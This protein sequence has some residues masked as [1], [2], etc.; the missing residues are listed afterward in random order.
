VFSVYAVR[1]CQNTF[2]SVSVSVWVK[3]IMEMNIGGI[4]VMLML[5]EIIEFCIMK[6]QSPLC[7]EFRILLLLLCARIWC[8]YS[9]TCDLCLSSSLRDENYFH[10]CFNSEHNRPFFMDIIVVL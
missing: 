7:I 4:Y 10:V 2:T 8:V 5:Y 9:H 3:V 1:Y 6:C